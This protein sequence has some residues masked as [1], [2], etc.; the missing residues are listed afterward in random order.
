MTVEIGHPNSRIQ[1]EYKMKRLGKETQ[2][3]MKKSH[4]V[5]QAALN[6]ERPDMSV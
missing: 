5:S 2:S 6:V 4:E 3:N 1:K